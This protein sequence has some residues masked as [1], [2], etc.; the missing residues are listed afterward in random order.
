M[1][2]DNDVRLVMMVIMVKLIMVVGS[3]RMD[4]CCWL[5]NYVTIMEI[6][7]LCYWTMLCR[8]KS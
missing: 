3:W 8:S 5:I 7:N 2:G 1:N 6:L 4:G